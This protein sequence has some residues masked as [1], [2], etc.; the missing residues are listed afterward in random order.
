MCAA[1]GARLE[2]PIVANP[3]QLL[4]LRPPCMARMSAT[5]VAFTTYNDLKQHR[6]HEVTA[7][8]R[9][10]DRARHRK[11]VAESTSIAIKSLKWNTKAPARDALKLVATTHTQT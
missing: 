2:L 5:L 6:V 7:A 3:L 8:L 4:G 9:D 1:I 10:G 11:I